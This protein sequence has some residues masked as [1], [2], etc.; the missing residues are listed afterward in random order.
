MNASSKIKNGL[1]TAHSSGK[2][3]FFPKPK[4]L[5]IEYVP[6]SPVEFVIGRRTP[7]LDPLRPLDSVPSLVTAGSSTTTLAKV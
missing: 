2:P 5:D 6:S 3:D 1:K 7:V 4:S